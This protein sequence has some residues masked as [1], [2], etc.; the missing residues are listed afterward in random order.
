MRRMVN[1]NKLVKKPVLCIEKDIH[2]ESEI[3]GLNLEKGDYLIDLHS[4]NYHNIAF[5]TVCEEAYSIST[6]TLFNAGGVGTAVGV[7][8]Y[9]GQTKSMEIVDT[10]ENPI[11]IEGHLDIYKF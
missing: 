7:Y 6:A 2:D 9:Y 11:T 1:I 3:L 4:S 8:E 10:Q 5:L